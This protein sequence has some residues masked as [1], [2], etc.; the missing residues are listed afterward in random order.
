MLC[1]YNNNSLPRLRAYNLYERAAKYT[2]SRT[3]GDVSWAGVIQSALDLA[4][5]VANPRAM[6]CAL[7]A[8]EG[9]QKLGWHRARGEH[10]L[11]G[12][13]VR[14]RTQSPLSGGRDVTIHLDSSGGWLHSL[15]PSL[16]THSEENNNSSLFSIPLLYIYLF[17]Y[18]VCVHGIIFCIFEFL[19]SRCWIER[20]V[21]V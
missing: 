20:W 11:R 17:I 1:Q 19:K 5:Q 8:G 10:V 13:S 15:A 21:L 14:Y 16:Y 6:T 3:K 7:P 9:V 4:Q 12:S 18:F 2:C